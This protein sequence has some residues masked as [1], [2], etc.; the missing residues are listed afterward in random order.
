MILDGSYEIWKVY[1]LFW[2]LA[3]TRLEPSLV[4]NGPHFGELVGSNLLA[5]WS[6]LR[7]NI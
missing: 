4:T 6:L 2:R 1:L 5:E 7:A 3:A